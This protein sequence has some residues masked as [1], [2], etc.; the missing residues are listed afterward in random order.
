MRILN[1][2]TVTYKREFPQNL[3]FMCETTSREKRASTTSNFVY[4]FFCRTTPEECARMHAR[5][6]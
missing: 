2:K 1:A 4:D 6:F 5:V 3:D